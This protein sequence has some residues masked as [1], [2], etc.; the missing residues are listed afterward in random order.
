MRGGAKRP[1]SADLTARHRQSHVRPPRPHQKKAALGQPSLPAPVV[2]AVA[3][4]SAAPFRN[5]Q[6]EFL[7]I[8]VFRKRRSFA[9]HDHASVLEN[10]AVSRKTQRHMR[11]LLGEQEGGALLLSTFLHV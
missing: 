4:L 6:I 11:V 3:K 5:A 2:L 7:D 10:I 8:L 9:V 1:G